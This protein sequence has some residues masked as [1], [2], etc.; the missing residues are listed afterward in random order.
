MECIVLIIVR[1]FGTNLRNGAFQNLKP[2]ICV[3][4]QMQINMRNKKELILVCLSPNYIS[5]YLNL[6]IL[7]QVLYI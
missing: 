4:L 6:S 2:V 3:S 7:T 1:H 5:F